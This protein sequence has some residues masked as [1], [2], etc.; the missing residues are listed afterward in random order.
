VGLLEDPHSPWNSERAIGTFNLLAR[1]AGGRRDSKEGIALDQASIEVVREVVEDSLA[2]IRKH[3]FIVDG[4]SGRLTHEQCVRWI[5]CAGRES[6]SFPDIL[7][8]MIEIVSDCDIRQVLQSNLEDEFGNGNPDHAHFKH[9]LHL[10]RKIG[11]S[12]TDFTSQL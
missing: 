10:I 12:E 8:N 11:L 9:Y 3:K 1:Y 7:Q 4:F 6:R 5:M 2:R